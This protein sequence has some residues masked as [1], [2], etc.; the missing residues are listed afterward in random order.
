MKAYVKHK[1]LTILEIMLVIC[2][3]AVIALMAARQY[4]KYTQAKN[5]S[6]L[7]NSVQI[8]LSAMQT[9]YNGTCDTLI[10][11]PYQTDK[12]MQTATIPVTMNQLTTTQSG[13]AAPALSSNEAS[14]VQNPFNPSSG[15]N[16]QGSFSMLINATEFPFY[17]EVDVAFSDSMSAQELQ[18]IASEVNPGSIS[19]QTMKWSY[20]PS[21]QTQFS[22]SGTR[23]MKTSLQAAVLQ[24]YA[25]QL[26]DQTGQLGG[27][28][29]PCNAVEA[30]IY[31]QEQLK[32]N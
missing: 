22:N 17:L 9:Y 4:T 31:R 14:L 29:V 15:T 25:L 23:A 32:G 26:Y 7:N 12:T 20:I 11:Q 3:A 28:N 18:A 27:G 8:V 30:Y 6:I 1:A 13:Q 2:L 10:L 24:Q 19:G 5:V 21:T 16:G